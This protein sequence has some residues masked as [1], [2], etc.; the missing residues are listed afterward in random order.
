MSPTVPAPSPPRSLSQTHVLPLPAPRCPAPGP[1]RHLCLRSPSPCLS[2]AP[3]RQ[4]CA[5]DGS[6]RPPRAALRLVCRSRQG[7]SLA[8]NYV[9]SAAVGCWPLA[10]VSASGHRIRQAGSRG[11]DHRG[12]LGRRPLLPLQTAGLC[13][14]AA[15]AGQLRPGNSF[16]LHRNSDLRS[17]RSA[18]P[19]SV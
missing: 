19:R 13:P 7:E 4:G 16:P 18:Q 9:L 3:A 14:R 15:G 10:P 6:P 5:A 11:P 8:L 12:S 17:P 2:G 1:R